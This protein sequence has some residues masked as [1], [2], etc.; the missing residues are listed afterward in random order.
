MT[1]DLLWGGTAT[2][3][4]RFHLYGNINAGTNPTASISGRT[5]NASLIVNNDGVG[6]IFVASTSG[7]TVF[8]ID[9]YGDQWIW[10]TQHGP[11]SDFAEYY[12]KANPTEELL[13]GQLICLAPDGVTKC[14]SNNP[15]QK[16][17]GVISDNALIAGN[18]NHA[19]DP[20]YALVGMVGQLGVWVT[21]DVKAGDPLTYSSIPGFAVKATSAGNII[22]Y[23]QK[24]NNGQQMRVDSVIQPTFYDPDFAL[25][26]PN[27][28][29]SLSLEI[30]NGIY[31]VRD[32][33]GNSINNVN[34]FSKLLVANITAGFIDAQSI[35]T[36]SLALT[37]N[38]FTIAG[39][40][41]S[42]YV[43]NIVANYLASNS[44]LLTPIAQTDQVL[45]NIISPLADSS[46]PSL[47]LRNSQIS[48]LSSGETVS[49]FDSNGNASFSGTLTSNSIQ[50]NNAS[51]SGNLA[52]NTINSQTSNSQLLTAGEATVSGTLR[53]NN[54]IADNIQGLD[55]KIGTLAAV[56]NGSY[57]PQGS[58]SGEFSN[59]FAGVVNA[60][61]ITADFGIFEQGITSMGPITAT[62][63]TAIDTLGVGSNFTISNNAINTLGAELAL[64]SLRQ[65]DIT[66]QGGL[67]RM[68]TDGNM[69]IAGNLNLL[70]EIDAVH[71]VFSGTVSTP[72]L[73]TSI[74]SPLA[75][76]DLTIKLTDK[77]ASEG[78][79]LRITDN[80]NKEV[81]AVDNKGNIISSGSA[82]L[83]KLNFNL[84]GEAQASS[85]TEAIAT[86]SAGFATL[87]A[88]QPEI[89]IKN[90]NVTE[91]SL[92]YITPF[93][94]TDN[95]V[96]YLLRQIPQTEDE[97]G[98]FTVG[99][100]G[101]LPT[102]NIQ[103]NWL[104]VN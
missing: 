71:G 55:D 50:T 30:Q 43:E 61:T 13:A 87:R 21:G 7:N 27:I 16:L 93:G 35:V 73:A 95:K 70:G 23:A 98:S 38:N 49:W 12:K 28:F 14:T 54:L 36:K 69:N 37:T 24:D 47:E 19:N 18:S 15:S 104:I 66:F 39:Q 84:V 80:Q 100:S 78:S 48:I 72:A 4:A 44:Q 99:A 96:L 86:G 60:T 11:R 77:Q 8:V 29:D 76:D 90:P 25:Q 56:L 79:K 31:T 33:F 6:D 9:R 89:T 83:S 68:D 45:T 74:I 94:D 42:S 20:G 1:A 101:T 91:K 26:N 5:S 46:A 88:N 17:I 85:L 3:S 63:I 75:G 10:G 102:Q 22:G 65:A 51:V 59:L 53:T 41:I 81:L 34:A 67:I 82:T 40:S 57:Q 92:I 62:D 32:A 2:L 97:E 52:A 103:F 58:G 64:Q